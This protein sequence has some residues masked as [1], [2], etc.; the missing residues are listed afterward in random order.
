M[1][2]TLNENVACQSKPLD[3]RNQR[4]YC[5]KVSTSQHGYTTSFH[6]T[7]DRLQAGVNSLLDVAR[8]T[9]KEA[10]ADAT[11]LVERLAGRRTTGLCRT[12]LLMDFKRL[13]I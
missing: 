9:Y 11:E 2:E 4:T 7:F 3:L 6:L 10:S 1:A 12:F 8:Q 13:M 5:V